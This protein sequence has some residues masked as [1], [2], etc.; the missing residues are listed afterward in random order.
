MILVTGAAGQLGNDLVGALVARHGKSAVLATDLRCCD[1]LAQTGADTAALDVTDAQ[2]VA[3]FMEEGRFD[4][5]Y[6]LAGILSARGEKQPDLCWNVNVN[7][8]KNVLDAVRGT[9]TRVFW[10]SSIAVFGPDTPKHRTPQVTI[11]NPTTM[12]GAAKAAGE[13]LCDYAARKFGVDVRSVRYPGIISY[14]APPG[15]GTTDF[16]VDMFVQAVRHGQ[17]TCFV[18]GSTRLPMMYGPDAVKAALDLMHASPASIS[19]RTSYNLT[20]FSFSAAELA[21]A[22]ESRVPGFVCDYEPDFRQA[23]ADTW[24]QVIDDSRARQDWGW[25]PDYDI[26]AMVDDMLSHLVDP[27]TSHV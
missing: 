11:K 2:A 12:Y 23:I 27:A 24:P 15:G 6:H 8:L 19:V 3:S 26:T 13:L 20:A 9:K 10:P 25:H 1:Q 18:R 4:Q 16:A 5:I 22:I 21:E 17:Y 14:G 7:G